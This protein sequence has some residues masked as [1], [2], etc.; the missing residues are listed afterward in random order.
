MPPVRFLASQRHTYIVVLI[1]LLGK[2]MPIYFYYAKKKLVCV[3]IVALFSCQSSS[4]FKYTKSNIYSSC[5]IQS[6][7]D[8][9]YIFSVY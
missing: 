1:L 3:I 2:V 4:Y 8:I 6:V 9:K 7:L 5:D